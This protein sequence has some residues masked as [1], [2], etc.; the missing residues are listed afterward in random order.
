[1]CTTISKKFKDLCE[2]TAPQAR[3]KFMR[4]WA[5]IFVRKNCTPDQKVQAKIK[6]NQLQMS[7]ERNQNGRATRCKLDA[8]FAHPRIPSSAPVSSHRS[9]HFFWKIDQKKTQNQIFLA[10]DRHFRSANSGETWPADA[11]RGAQSFEEVFNPVNPLKPAKMT[12]SGAP[13]QTPDP[14]HNLTH[15]PTP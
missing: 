1:M 12:F 8:Q 2:D 3:L 5:P 7:R 15:A 9:L 6:G 13:P 14:P 10:P 4:N 11:T